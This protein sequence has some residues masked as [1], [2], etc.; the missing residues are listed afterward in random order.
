[1]RNLQVLIFFLKIC[2]RIDICVFP[3]I[4]TIFGHEIHAWMVSLVIYLYLLIK[5]KFSETTLERNLYASVILFNNCAKL[6]CPDRFSPDTI[7]QIPLPI[8]FSIMH[9]M[10]TAL[11]NIS[12]ITKFSLVLI[13]L[14]H[15]G[16]N[17]SKRIG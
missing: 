11:V 2:H 5:K 3:S 8:I 14:I 13:D 15:F 17:G 16:T 7:V 9:K 1:M 4:W 6:S 10:I 12:P